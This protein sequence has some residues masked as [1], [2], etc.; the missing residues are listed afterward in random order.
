LNTDRR[1]HQWLTAVLLLAWT[2]SASAQPKAILTRESSIAVHV[3]R[4]GLFSIF[5]HDHEIAAPITGGGVDLAAHRVDVR[6]DARDM[7]VRDAGI[8]EK[9]RAEIQMTMLGP[10]VLD[11]TR[12]PEI[13][14]RSTSIE[15]AGK[16]AWKIIGSLTLHGVP[17]PLTLEVLEQAGR[18]TGHTFLKQTDFGIQPVGVAGGTVRVKDE[19]RIDFDIRL[20]H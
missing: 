5:G 18:Y 13:A 10:E 4:S 3:Y 6:V 8:S 11:V 17:Q 19:V 1:N 12:Y 14:F 16:G 2:G 7:R 15:S 9:D 20:A